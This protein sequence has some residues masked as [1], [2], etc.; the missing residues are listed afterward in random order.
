MQTEYIL[1]AKRLKYTKEQANH[2]I[3]QVHV[4]KYHTKIISVRERKK[5][6]LKESNNTF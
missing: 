6:D 5:L 4:E 2:L 3:K 1:G